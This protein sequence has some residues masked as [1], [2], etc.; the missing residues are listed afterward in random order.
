MGRIFLISTNTCCNPYAVYPLGMSTA[1]GTLIEAGYT[2]RQ[3]D[4]LASNRDENSLK[5]EILE[6]QPD[7]VGISVRNIDNTDSLCESGEMQELD[8]TKKV[9]GIIRQNTGSPIIAGG[10]A[11]SVLPEPVSKYLGADISVVGE[12]ERSITDIIK[13]ILNKE[14]PG[15]EAENNLCDI[16]Q[17]SPC[18]DPAIIS[19]Y[20]EK[21]GIIGLQSKRG[22]PY[23]CCYCSY[24]K[25]EGNAIRSRSAEAVIADIEKLKR[26]FKVDTIFF[27]DSVFNDPDENYLDLAEIMAVKNL[28]V[29]WAAYMSPHGL[30]NKALALCKRAGL[31]AA[32]LGTDATTD[33]TLEAMSKPFSWEDVR[34]TN[35]LFVQAQIPCA[36]F[37]IFG[38]PEETEGTIRE[39]LENIN[40]LESCVVMGFSGIRIYPGTSIYTRAIKEGFIKQADTLL[41]PVY[42]V[43]PKVDKKWMDNYITEA[44]AKRPDRVFPPEKGQAIVTTLRKMGYK[45]LLWERM[46]S[47]KQNG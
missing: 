9:I 33:T 22:C 10:T 2:V 5:R 44:W 30:T 23:Y 3:F 11:I 36:H 35:E 17:S 28:G 41:E 32:E 6:F 37:V 15:P 12:S 16:A 43:S 20:R 25:I 1:A 21:S 38:G 14:S 39:G 45:G 27:V 42:Y 7:V 31:Y 26:D 34:Q 46:V 24:P 4:W 40:C 19:F 8:E 13:K 47:F 29:K 18:F